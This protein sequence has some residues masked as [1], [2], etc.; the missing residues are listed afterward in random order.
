MCIR[1][2]EHTYYNE[3]E[4]KYFWTKEAVNLGENLIQSLLEIDKNLT[5]SSNKTPMPEW[6]TV[7]EFTTSK[8][9]SIEQSIETNNKKILELTESNNNLNNLLLEENKLKDLLFETG[10]LLEDAVTN[11]LVILRI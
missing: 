5:T 2:R 11:A 3:K 9:K 4:D 7:E 8:A 6:A 10:K 1:D